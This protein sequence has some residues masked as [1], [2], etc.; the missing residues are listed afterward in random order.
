[1]GQEENHLSNG[2]LV[3]K[4]TDPLPDKNSHG[5]NRDG[6]VPALVQH[7]PHPPLQFQEDLQDTAVTNAYLSSM[8]H[9]HLPKFQT[10]N[11]AG[12]LSLSNALVYM[13]CRHLVKMNWRSSNL[14]SS[15]EMVTVDCVSVAPVSKAIL[16][17]HER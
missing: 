14:N 8:W 16:T 13:P 1:M 2:R 5:T 17:A 6:M 3:G 7:H 4:R 11:Q 15:E 12:A 9:E 10:K